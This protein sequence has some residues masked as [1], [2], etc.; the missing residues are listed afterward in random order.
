MKNII[1]VALCLA[2]GAAFAWTHGIAVGPGG[3]LVT[4]ANDTLTTN[5]NDPLLPQ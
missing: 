5:A 1:I 4:N 2:S 3:F